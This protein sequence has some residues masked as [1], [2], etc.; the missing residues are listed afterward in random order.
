MRECVYSILMK[1]K[2]NSIPLQ[3]TI[4]FS[5]PVQTKD[6]RKVTIFTT[7]AR[8]DYPVVGQIEGPFSIFSWGPD[9]KYGLGSSVDLV[10]V[11]EKKVVPLGPEDIRVGDIVRYK[12]ESETWQAITALKR[13]TQG[14]H[15]FVA[16]ISNYYLDKKITNLLLSHDNGKTWQ[17]FSKEIE[18]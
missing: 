12:D 2:D 6:G 5:K 9:G 8:G 16:G 14:K 1:D 10:N 11:K 18:A 7:Q 15:F 4:D 3:S 13:D 17:E